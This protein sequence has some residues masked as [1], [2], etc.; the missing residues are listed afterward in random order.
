MSE[1]EARKF[2]FEKV[3]NKNLVKH[4]LA[5]GAI[6]GYLAEKL[7]Q[8]VNSWTIAGILHDIDYETTK[9]DPSKHSLEGAA[10]L[11]VMGLSKEITEAVKTHNEMHGIAPDS[12]MAKALFCCDPLSG[13]IVAAT[14]VLPSKKIADLTTD[15]IVNRFYEKSFAK[16]ANRNIIAKC[17]EYLNLSLKDFS[18][19]GLEAMQKISQDL[20]L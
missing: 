19:I 4:C 12:L 5:V 8:D 16:G 11:E 2:L 13:L 9:D 14:L 18:G 17:Q 10:I 3:K 20:E 6:M 7:N 1:Q 15:N